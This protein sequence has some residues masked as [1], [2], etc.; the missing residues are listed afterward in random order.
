MVSV[1]KAPVMPK[2]RL[3]AAVRPLIFRFTL[4]LLELSVVI[5]DI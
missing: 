5:G 4:Q 3:V 1:E 2:I